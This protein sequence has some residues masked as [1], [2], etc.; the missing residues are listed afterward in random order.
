MKRRNEL[1][2]GRRQNTNSLVVTRQAVNPGLDENEAELAVLVLAVALKV[3]SHGDS[4]FFIFCFRINREERGK[5][6]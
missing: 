6:Q 4:L 3:L 1:F 2:P 5:G